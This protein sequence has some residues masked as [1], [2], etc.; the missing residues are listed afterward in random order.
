MTAAHAEQLIQ[1]NVLPRKRIQGL[2]MWAS[3]RQG[4]PVNPE[5]FESLGIGTVQMIP[6]L[7]GL[8]GAW[9]TPKA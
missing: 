2:R 6:L 3:A 7:H 1:Q 4:T 9:P 8:V 5:I